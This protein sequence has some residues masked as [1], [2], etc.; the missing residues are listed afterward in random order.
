MRLG[1]HM[2]TSKY[3]RQLSGQMRS[4]R[5]DRLA[6]QDWDCIISVAGWWYPVISREWSSQLS[7]GSSC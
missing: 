2:T 4:F 6:T 3:Q 1:S 7:A 5:R